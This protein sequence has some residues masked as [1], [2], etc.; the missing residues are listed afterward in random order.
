MSW[1]GYLE[2]FEITFY[3][4]EM[5]T[6]NILSK[7][8]LLLQLF[9]LSKLLNFELQIIRFRRGSNIEAQPKIDILGYQMK[10]ISAL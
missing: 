8:L 6:V 5:K 4:D 2:L 9:K 3:F 1:F 7:K 10:N